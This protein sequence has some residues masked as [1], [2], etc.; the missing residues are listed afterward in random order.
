MQ[1][2][3]AG[4]PLFFD[5]EKS[6]SCQHVLR[7]L[8]SE[9][10]QDFAGLLEDLLG[11]VAGC[12]PRRETRHEYQPRPGR[13]AGGDQVPVHRPPSEATVQLRPVS[14][15]ASRSVPR[16]CSSPIAPAPERGEAT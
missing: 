7:H 15:D 1:L 16:L 5:R 3:H 4:A 9:A 13:P 2:E 10:N 11:C 6:R 12:F 14:W 8:L